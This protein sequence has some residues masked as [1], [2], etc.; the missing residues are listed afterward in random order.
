[1]AAGY[2]SAGRTGTRLRE[3]GAQG[4]L[5][6]ACPR[7]SIPVLHC[8]AR[9]LRRV[10]STAHLGGGLSFSGHSSLTR[11]DPLGH[12]IGVIGG[13]GIGPEVV[14]EALKVVRAA[15]VDLDTVDYDLGGARYLRDGE[16]LPD[17]V[18]DEL[19][20]LDAILLG[21]VGTPGCRPASSS[22]ACCCACASP[23]TSTSTCAPSTA[24]ASTSSSCG[25]TPRAPTPARAGSC[26]RARPPRWP[27]R[28]R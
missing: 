9:R 12:K 14:A 1:M 20:G 6:E 3:A 28:V 11:Q 27:P 15:G 21:A 25:R 19:R 16:V 18:L 2:R 24:L 10:L 5:G 13:D 4:T 23:S 22:G 7:V 26:A 8:S 17:T